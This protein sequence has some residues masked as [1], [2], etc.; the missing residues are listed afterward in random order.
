MI[1]KDDKENTLSYVLKRAF[2]CLIE[3]QVGFMLECATC[4]Y[5]RLRTMTRCS[6]SSLSKFPRHIVLPK[7]LIRK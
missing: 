2:V 5:R 7:Q 4:V 3:S 1:T 6:D